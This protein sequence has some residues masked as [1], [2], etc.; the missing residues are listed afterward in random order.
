MLKCLLLVCYLCWSCTGTE[1]SES[2]LQYC[3]HI[4]GENLKLVWQ[5]QPRNLPTYIF[6]NL[7]HCPNSPTVEDTF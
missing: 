6:A 7:L 3:S 5:L 4:K 1:I 2:F